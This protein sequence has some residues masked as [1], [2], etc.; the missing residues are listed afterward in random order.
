MCVTVSVLSIGLYYRG[1]YFYS[2]TGG[3]EKVQRYKHRSSYRHAVSLKSDNPGDRSNE[4]VG[5]IP[6]LSLC[7]LSLSISGTQRDAGGRMREA[8]RLR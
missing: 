5:N 3:G 2:G 4:R 1:T 6:I 8:E 7:L